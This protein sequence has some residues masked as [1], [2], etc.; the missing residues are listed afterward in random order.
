ML[1]SLKRSSLSR[2]S[3]SEKQQ[4]FN[5]L[6]TSK[7][8]KKKYRN[9]DW[10][11]DESLCDGVCVSGAQRKAGRQQHLNANPHLTNNIHI[12]QVILQWF[13][14]AYWE[15]VISFC[16]PALNVETF[17]ANFQDMNYNK[18]AFI[19]YYTYYIWHI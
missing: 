2:R 15:L 12:A 6:I 11:Q 8:G 7:L 16:N 13:E 10:N 5:W 4:G 19:I 18:T 14:T 9:E 3:S 17:P 1:S